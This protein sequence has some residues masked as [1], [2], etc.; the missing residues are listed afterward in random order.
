[1]AYSAQRDEPAA[2]DIGGADHA[3]KIDQLLLSGLDHYFRGRFERAIDVWTRVLF[4]DSS[5]ARARTYI[6]R[7]RAAVAERVRESEALLHAGV[8]ACDRGDVTEARALLTTAIER[9]G[10]DDEARAVLDLVERLEV[11]GVDDPAAAA[12]RRRAGARRARRGAVTSS[13]TGRRF[14]MVPWVLLIALFAGATVALYLAG[15]WAQ[16]VPI[17]LV[18]QADLAPVPLRVPPAPLPVPSV[19]QLALE[20]AKALVADDRHAEALGVLAAVGL[21]DG[22]RGDVDTLRA[23]IQQEILSRLPEM[24]A[25]AAVEYADRPGG[26]GVTR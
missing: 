18:D 9:G 26:S 16:L 15:A 23:T 11:A 20:R 21:G 14:R 4:L 7:A 1:M 13:D 22:L 5:H 24:A 25:G 19:P 6:D 3:A 8:E 12:A 17:R 2:A 10:A